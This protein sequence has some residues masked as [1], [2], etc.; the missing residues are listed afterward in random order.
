MS[1]FK[2]LKH[3]YSHKPSEGLV[4]VEI[5]GKKSATTRDFFR[6][7]AKPLYFPEYFGEN[8]DALFDLLCDLS[9]MDDFKTIHF[10]LKSYD[11]FLSK[12]DKNTR[13]D[14]LH[15][16]N[17]AATEWK[18]LKGRKKVKVEIHVEP[19]ERVVKD[20]ADAEL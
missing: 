19:S 18:N 3:A 16:L 6:Q 7:I 9:W 14:I 12:E 4:I 8:L 20:L 1:N 10:V 13:W 5:D 11:E 2:I 15:I 17:D